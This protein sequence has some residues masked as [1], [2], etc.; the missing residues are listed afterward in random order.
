[1]K[2][3]HAELFIY[4]GLEVR[5]GDIAEIPLVTKPCGRVQ[6]IFDRALRGEIEMKRR[7]ASGGTGGERA[8]HSDPSTRA[9]LEFGEL[10]F[11]RFIRPP[12]EASFALDAQRIGEVVEVAPQDLDDLNQLLGR[13]LAQPGLD[14]GQGL[15]VLEAELIG[16]LLLGQA[17]GLASGFKSAGNNGFHRL[18]A[19]GPGTCL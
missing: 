11:A 16:E 15:A 2:H 10:V 17:P 19:P 3:Q 9:R 6:R 14:G 7:G 4:G 12:C 1:M 13:H 18:W 8:I 5:G